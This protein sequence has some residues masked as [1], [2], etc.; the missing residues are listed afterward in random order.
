MQGHA[1]KAQGVLSKA[2]WFLVTAVPSIA[3]FLSQ[4]EQPA[5]EVMAEQAPGGES[6]STNELIRAAA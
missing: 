2:A 4:G 5:R 3:P 6:L 1:G